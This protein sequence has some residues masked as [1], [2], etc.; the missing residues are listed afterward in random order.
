MG[1]L[2]VTGRTREGKDKT[3][4]KSKILAMLLALAMVLT[5]IPMMAFA[6][7]GISFT[8]VSIG[9]RKDITFDAEGNP[10]YFK[11]NVPESGLYKMYLYQD[12]AASYND[13][14]GVFLYESPNL[15]EDGE[16]LSDLHW[17]NDDTMEP[18]YHIF[19]LKA[20][21]Y[22]MEAVKYDSD[23]TKNQ[24]GFEFEETDGWV[25]NY[26][27][28]CYVGQPY[29]GVEAYNVDSEEYK[30]VDKVVS[31]DKD[32]VSIKTDKWKDENGKTHKNFELK[33]KKAGK[34][35][36]TVDYTTPE[37]T[38]VQQ[39]VYIRVKKYPKQI[40]SLKVSGKKVKVSKNKYTYFK[41][42]YKSTKASVKVALKK[43]WKIDGVWAFMYTKS[44]K[45]KEV[46]I[47]KKMITKGTSFK[48]PKKYRYM[49][50]GFAMNKGN[51]WLYYYIDLS[52]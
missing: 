1:S 23:E 26:S 49:N 4:K 13:Y 42:K 10:Q 44:G 19:K 35:T 36:I 41:G 9:N 47:T 12:Y 39:D 43:G 40:K 5:C 16:S 17:A 31:S 33:A 45:E 21:T 6:E 29:L 51:D 7:D 20:G 24:F 46:K 32:V 52:R 3:M 11:L 25:L 48:F 22:Y 14:F 38:K 15:S 18:D 27:N 34:V 28:V 2:P 8:D 50:I 30:A 37:G